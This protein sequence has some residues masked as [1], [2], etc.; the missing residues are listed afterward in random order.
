M[1][2]TF[3]KP[4]LRYKAKAP[5]PGEVSAQPDLTTGQRCPI[6]ASSRRFAQ[7]VSIAFTSEGASSD[8]NS[9]A[10]LGDIFREF[11][12]FSPSFFSP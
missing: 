6:P 2:S 8:D 4:K 10:A 5:P 12:I 3:P 11:G 9:E 7:L 1:R